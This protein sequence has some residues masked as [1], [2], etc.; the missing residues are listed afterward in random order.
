ME[1]EVEME[2][3]KWGEWGTETET[4]TERE[5]VDMDMCK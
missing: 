4:E 1:V 5:V 3:G 2:G